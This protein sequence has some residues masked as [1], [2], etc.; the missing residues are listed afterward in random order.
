MISLLTTRFNQ[1]TW[2]ENKTFRDKNNVACIYGVSQNITEKMP[3]HA[4]AFVIEMNNE[5]NQIEGIGL[6]R[7]SPEPVR[8]NVYE[9]Y[10]WNRYCYLGKY[11]Q[12]RQSLLQKNP[13]L[14]DVLDNLL[15]KG[16]A[17]MK[18]GVGMTLITEKV[19]HRMSVDFPLENEI[20]SVFLCESLEREWGNEMG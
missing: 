14:V 5:L 10:N 1:N 9:N 2:K 15:F 17:H 11:Y 18:R 7:N 6:I 13:H 16:K 12:D 4:L 8:Y 20:R 3:L 19:K